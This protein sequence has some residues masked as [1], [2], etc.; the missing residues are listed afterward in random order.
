MP[1]PKIKL[2]TL[3][4][5][6]NEG[7]HKEIQS[8]GQ[9]A[10]FM[11]QATQSSRVFR[12]VGRSFKL[13]IKYNAIFAIRR[14]QYALLHYSNNP[15]VASIL[16]FSVNSRFADRAIRNI[17]KFSGGSPSKTAREVKYQN[18][19]APTIITESPEDWS[20]IG[21][22]T[23][24]ALKYLLEN[25]EFDFLF[26]TNTSSYLDVPSLLDFLETK[27]KENFYAGVVSSVLGNTRFA[28]GAGILVSR[29]IVQRICD[30]S[31]V[32]KHGLVDDAAFAELVANLQD[33]SV[34]LVDLPRLDFDSL[35]AA[36]S[37]K[38]EIIKDYFHF[39]CKADS[40]QETI[41]I[42]KHIFEVKGA[43]N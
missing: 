36:K 39:R 9:D 32:W 41:D 1:E 34:E 38:P 22:K 10:T 5:S 18:E 17:P 14:W 25:Y 33:P 37:T 27:P 29:D 40:A 26:R 42:M 13:P 4:L 15:L 43:P 12:Y 31:E 19:L 20:L 7:H 8:Q 11:R 3:I 24:L 23:I 35:G 28:S 16:R 21:L 6:F 30:N 2:L